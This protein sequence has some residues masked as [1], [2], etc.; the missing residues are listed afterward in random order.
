MRESQ[1]SL[2]LLSG[3]F[4]GIFEAVGD[5]LLLLE[6]ETG[7]ILDA[8]RRAG[9]LYG[10]EREEFLRKKAGD[11]CAEGEDP[12]EIARKIVRGV[13]EKSPLVIDWRSRA[14][15]GR[16]IPVEMTLTRSR[17][18]G[19]DCIVSVVRETEPREREP[20]RR[21]EILQ[22]VID[23]LPVMLSFHDGT[24]RVIL[25]N[26]EF[27]RILGWTL[28]EA[29]KID[30]MAECYPDPAYRK[31]AW[32]HMAGESPGWK[33][34]KVR[35]RDGRFIESTWA[36]AHLPDG[37]RI[38]IGVDVAGR[39]RSEEAIAAA[40][41]RFEEMVK[42]KAAEIRESEEKF[43]RAFR[44]SPNSMV[45][46]TLSEGRFIEVNAA[47]EALTGYRREELL[48][49]ASTE[50]PFWGSGGTREWM[51]Q[52]VRRDGRIGNLELQLFRRDLRPVPV[53]FSAEQ[54]RIG[55]KACLLTVLTDITER[56]AAED[57]LRESELRFR[58][59]ADR[60]PQIVFEVDDRGKIIYANRV[61]WETFQYGR[62]DF[63][64]G[65][66]LLQVVEPACREQASEEFRRVLGGETL[67]GRE[68]VA[69]RKDGT[70][71]PVL[72]SA[73]P[74]E[75]N[76]R[77]TGVRGIA[78]DISGHKAAEKA[79]RESEDRFRSLADLLPLNVFETDAHGVFTYVNRKFMEVSGYDPH[80]F[81]RGTDAFQ[82]VRPEDHG[83]TREALGKVLAGETIAGM[84]LTAHRKDGSTYL[85]EVHASPI[86][87][88]GSITGVRG[89]TMDISGRRRSEE[90]LRQAQKF[91]AVGR[92]AGGV[93]HHLNN[94]M[95]V[96]AG[97][98][99]LL[100][101]RMEQ[102]NP[103]RREVEEIRKAG[104]RAA[105]LTGKLLSYGRRQ[106]LRPESVDLG[107]FL[108]EIEA[109]IRLTAGPWVGVS[110]LPAADAGIVLIDPSLLRTTVLQMVENG[111]EAMP[112]GGTLVVRAD[113]SDP[114]TEEGPPIPRGDYAM[115]SIADT[116]VGMDL[117]T[118]E[119]IF[120][121]FFTRKGLAEG[122]GLSLSSSYGF[123]RQSGGYVFVDSAPG[124]GAK[125]MICL[126]LVQD[127]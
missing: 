85:V 93:A 98:A 56:K 99:T 92:L 38:G 65:L 100:I 79:L 1:P 61:A 69:I 53:L 125:F 118:Q 49:H 101:D 31:E 13:A 64:E 115:L 123:I 35:S 117:E 84:E 26:G 44:I 89:A 104:E 21:P 116:G 33:D 43:N 62:E 73:S 67:S 76:G 94:L 74:I 108:K 37:S 20:L 41:D 47:F 39:K 80:D 36:N 126:P 59:L 32:M 60:L 107:A 42:E 19:R 54:I 9:E 77:I 96:V 28:E 5:P 17:I 97:Y 75:K 111:R 122:E 18:G 27:T 34:F 114:S 29:R 103:W 86:R 102:R 25:V 87:R 30:L 112:D 55:G 4:R 24:G 82:L 23:N 3:D 40:R 81:E 105:A 95:T 51:A 11:L 6:P 46:T 119:H 113:R 63:A 57:S 45:L 15:D 22:S 109:E 50:F 72:A 83:K 127:S 14:S 70:H 48:G 10:Y 7:A 2:G 78:M 124:K 121:P 110:V 68:Y 91:E 8:N 71:F 88:N 66:T 12:G 106:M 58:S 16:I 120:E 52:T 90:E